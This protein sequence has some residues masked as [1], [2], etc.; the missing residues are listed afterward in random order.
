MGMVWAL[1]VVGC[2]AATEAEPEDAGPKPPALGCVITPT[3][4]RG[5]ECAFPAEA[6]RAY[7]VEARGDVVPAMG[8]EVCDAAG[9]VAVERTFA[10]GVVTV[11]VAPRTRAGTVTVRVATP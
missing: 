9:C 1:L 10:P 5:G 2:G 11:Q 7:W 4:S 8:A 6:G 3:D